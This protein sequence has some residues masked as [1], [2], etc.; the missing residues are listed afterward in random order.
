MLRVNLVQPLS[1]SSDLGQSRPRLDLWTSSSIQEVSLKSIH[2]RR[3]KYFRLRLTDKIS[4]Q[5]KLVN[6]AYKP[7]TDPKDED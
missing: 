1:L 3:T 4:L 7:Q 6:G 2:T 5:N